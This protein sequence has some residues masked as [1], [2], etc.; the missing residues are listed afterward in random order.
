MKTRIIKV[1]DS[2]AIV[3]PD[4][5]ARGHGWRAGDE[6]DLE[7]LSTGFIAI[8][9]RRRKDIVGIARKLVAENSELIRRLKDL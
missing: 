8:E 5:I 6:L 2:H 3:I 1:G 4:E 9:S 7:E